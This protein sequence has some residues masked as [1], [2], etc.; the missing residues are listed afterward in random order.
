M[1]VRVADAYVDVCLSLLAHFLKFQ[2]LRSIE[3]REGILRL[4]NHLL[5]A[6][7]HVALLFDAGF[8][9][10]LIFLFQLRFRKASQFLFLD[11]IQ[12]LLVVVMMVA[13]FGCFQWRCL[14]LLICVQLRLFPLLSF[15][16]HDLVQN[17]LFS[18]F[19]LLRV[20][21]LNISRRAY[22]LA[23]GFLF[24][25][26]RRIL[27]AFIILSI[28]SHLRG[29]A[30]AA[31]SWG[32]A[33]LVRRLTILLRRPRLAP[34]CRLLAIAFDLEKVAVARLAGAAS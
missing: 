5:D 28:R 25:G 13:V 32:V 16:G 27:I 14:G 30:S 26:R 29:P 10:P 1:E 18:N 23:I 15:F 8:D 17:A 33:L 24:F 19:S 3:I 31:F 21:R 9:V 22:G 4:A 7:P 12:N 6:C 11:Q 20:I 2:V 34:S